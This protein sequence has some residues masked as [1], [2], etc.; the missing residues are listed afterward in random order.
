MDR[1]KHRFAVKF[2]CKLVKVGK[3]RDAGTAPCAP[4]V[5]NAYFAVGCGHAEAEC[6]VG[7]VKRDL[8]GGAHLSDLGARHGFGDFIEE[9]IVNKRAA[10]H[11]CEHS[12]NDALAE[13]VF[14]DDLFILFGLA[15]Q[16]SAAGCAGIKQEARPTSIDRGCRA[17]G[18]A[19][20]A[21][22]TFNVAD[23][24][25]VHFADR[26]AASALG[27]FAVFNRNADE[28][29]LVEK[30][31]DQSERAEEA[32]EEAVNEHRTEHKDDKKEEFPGEKRAEH[33]EHILVLGVREKS[34]STLKRS[35][36]AYVFAECGQNEL[37]E[38][39]NEGQREDENGEND[40]FQLREYFCEAI[41]L[42]LRGLDLIN[43][44]LNEPE[45]AKESADPAAEKERVEQD[46]AHHI[47]GDR[48]VCRRQRVLER[49]EGA[50]GGCRGAGIAVDSGRADALER[51]AIDAPVAESLE[52]GVEEKR[53][54]KLDQPALCRL[55][56]GEPFFD[57]HSDPSLSKTDA[58]GADS[59]CFLKN[60][61][62]SVLCQT[63]DDKR[64][65]GADKDETDDLFGVFGVIFCADLI[66][67]FTFGYSNFYGR[68]IKSR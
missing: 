42:D 37:A 15:G 7:I 62:K 32:A 10:K 5:D 3:L 19:V 65:S 59:D 57:F 63:D 64:T 14:L 24:R 4:E 67:F 12:R 47:I 27:A 22:D 38:G 41:F 30:A 17:F 28:G 11:N 68:R 53:G 55:V 50:S 29:D 51:P 8:L 58:L 18:N 16:G 6:L 23:L 26:K 54:V 56:R 25:D 20:A 31:V 1:D 40:V 48:L 60:V 52:I 46:D 13:R 9:V 33:R 45:G 66:G 35:R 39:V 21:L 2:A 44:V 61:V 36:R 43:E 34:D 49:A